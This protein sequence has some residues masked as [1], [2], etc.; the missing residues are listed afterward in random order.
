MP[1]G[2]RF[3]QRLKLPSAVEIKHELRMMMLGDSID[4]LP[5]EA[6]APKAA[7]GKNQ[8]CSVLRAG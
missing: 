8:G 4:A 3:G 6:A 2:F 7:E 1:N 5:R